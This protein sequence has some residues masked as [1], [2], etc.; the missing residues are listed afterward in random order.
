MFIRNENFKTFLKHYPIVSAILAIDIL[1]YLIFLLDSFLKTGLSYPL[2]QLSVGFN[3][4]ILQGEWWRLITPIFL[5]ITFSHLLFNAF[6]ILIFAPAIEAMFGKWYFLLVFLGSGIISNV[7]ALF[8]EPAASM[9]YG[10]S[11]AIFGLFGL[12]LYMVIF[13]R[14][15]ISNQDRTIVI[16]FIVISLIGTFVYPD[17]DVFGH[18]FG[19]LSGFAFAPLLCLKLKR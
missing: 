2:F 4:A 9:H 7:A 19:L 10:A 3:G 12:Y 15:L 13:R 1:V 6:A 8:L 11:S 14:D 16:V 17:V 18:L 5:H